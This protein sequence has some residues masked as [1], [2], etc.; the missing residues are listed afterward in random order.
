[1]WGCI[2]TADNQARVAEWCDRG[3]ATCGED[4][5]GQMIGLLVASTGWAVEVDERKLQELKHKFDELAQ[6]DWPFGKPALH[7]VQD[8]V[9][10]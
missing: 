2:A 7:L 3:F 8:C 9:H 5:G 1:M 10:V 6:N 4:V